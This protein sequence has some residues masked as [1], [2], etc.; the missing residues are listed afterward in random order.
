MSRSKRNELIQKVKEKGLAAVAKM[1]DMIPRELQAK[2]T[3]SFELDE[4]VNQ[5][6]I[7][8]LEKFAD[9]ILAKV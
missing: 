4:K 9:R 5:S 8:Q 3:E 6:Q 1:Y 7:D 2:I